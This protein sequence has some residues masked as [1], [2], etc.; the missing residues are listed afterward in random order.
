MKIHATM[1]MI[2]IFRK[3]NLNWKS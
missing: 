2:I 1:Q 3:K